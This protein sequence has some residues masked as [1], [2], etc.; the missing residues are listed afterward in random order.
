MTANASQSSQGT[1]E[2]PRCSGGLVVAT[3]LDMTIDFAAP[4]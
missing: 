3:P 2:G 1:R 4:Q